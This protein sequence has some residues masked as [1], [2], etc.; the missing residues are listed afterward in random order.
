MTFLFDFSRLTESEDG[1]KDYPADGG[2]DDDDDLVG[3]DPDDEDEEEAFEEEEEEEHLTSADS[4]V[5]SPAAPIPFPSK[6]DFARLLALPTPPS[7]LLTLLSSLLCYIASPPLPLPSPPTY[8]SLTYVET[9][10][11]YRAAGI[12]QDTNEIYVR[13]EDAQDDRPFLRGQVN[14][15]RRDRQY[16]LNTA[17]LVE[18]DARVSREAWAQSM[19]CSRAVHDELHTYQTHTQTLDTRIF[20][21]E[22]L[23]T[24]LVSQTK[25]L[26]TQLIAALGRIDTL[27]AREPAHTDDPLVVYFTKMPPKRNA[28]MTTTTPMTD[29]QI[30]AL[31]AQGVVDALAERNACRS[32]NGDDSH[33]SRSDGRRRMPIS[34]ECTY[35][36]FLKC[37]P[38]NF[39]V[40][41][42]V[43][44]A[45][46]TL[47]GN[48]L[49]WWNSHELALLCGRMFLEESDKVEKYIGG[50][51]DMI[52][53]SVMTSKPKKMWD[54]IE[55]ATELM[56]QKISSLA[57]CQIENKRK[58]D[59][60]FRD[61]QNQQQPNKRQNTGR[62][63][64][65]EPSE[66]SEYGGS[67]PK[68]SK[69]N[70][71]HNSLCA[72]KCHKC[73]KVGHLAR[74]CR[75]SGNANASNNQ[76][77]TGANQK[78]TGCYE[79][80]AQGHFKRECPKLKNKNRGNQG[81]NGNA[82]KKCM[83]WEMR[84]QT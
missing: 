6:V 1:P 12:Q 57:E 80:G 59:D 17:M 45:T 83:W 20:A 9:P 15:L 28:A 71:H 61:N 48:A 32:R 79:C 13:F 75:S 2:D 11:G 84:G 16:H 39:K 3:D 66:K 31:I 14:M 52:Q 34:R 35:S 51:P 50:L 44:Y 30:K 63:Y 24:T 76:R 47:H 41:N 56:D 26:Q 8:T 67:L 22:A 55:F 21:L 64:T 29:A 46:H 36:D 65:A 81:R 68:C 54:A 70:Y 53:G 27:E 10:L 77:A 4:T 18:S 19:G 7:S 38:F 43:K 5:V 40:R 33:D 60:N 62:A 23:V 49:T 74:D 73:N 82:P 25:S 58:Q 42:Q 69:C 37:Q 78:G 72:P